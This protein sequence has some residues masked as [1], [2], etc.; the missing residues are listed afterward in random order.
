MR[1][2]EIND[3]GPILKG[4]I[5]RS[6]INS[7]QQ[8][9]AKCISIGTTPDEPD[10][11]A[12]LTLDFTRDF[13]DILKTVFPKTKFSVTGVYCHQ[14][15]LAQI[16]G[17]SPSPEIG[18]ILFVY[19]HTD[20]TG[21]KRLNS[22]LFQAK[23][24]RSPVVAVSPSDRHQLTLYTEWPEFSYGRADALNGHMRDILPKTLHDGAQY[25]LIDNHPVFG[26]SGRPGTF[27]MGCAIPSQVLS[28]D[29]DLA[30]ELVDFLKF[31][32]GRTIEADGKLTK[33]HWTRLIFD[34]LEITK[35]KAS[36]RNNSGLKSFPRLKTDEY[37]GCCY[38]LPGKGV[39]SIFRDLH[40]GL[41]GGDPDSPEGK[42]SDDENEGIS[43]V[44][45]ESSDNLG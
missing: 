32:S 42:F 12:S 22:L 6:I 8:V 2:D 37:D 9:V 20:S 38:F 31:K 19:I 23:M 45:V 3:A 44:L 10:F 16:P 18:D 30:T 29:N 11:I 26:L 17:I 1:A 27:P 25:L 34:M 24:S 36:K 14:K 15:P 41:N 35:K 5:E 13:G 4:L 39:E 28:L 40:E 7:V 33:D 21:T 43:V